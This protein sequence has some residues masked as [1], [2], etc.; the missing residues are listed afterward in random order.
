MFLD[1]QGQANEIFKVVES[2]ARGK[3]RNVLFAACIYIACRDNDMTR[4]MR[5]IYIWN[6]K[7]SCSFLGVASAIVAESAFSKPFV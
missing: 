7:D 4:T 5:G 1:L 6:L 2:Y 3:E